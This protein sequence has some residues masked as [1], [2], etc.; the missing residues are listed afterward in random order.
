MIRLR[1]R[2]VQVEVET[3]RH[4]A[5]DFAEPL[6]FGAQWLGQ[7]DGKLRTGVGS[8]FNR[9]R[10]R[11]ASCTPRKMATASFGLKFK[12]SD[13]LD[14]NGWLQGIVLSGAV[15]VNRAAHRCWVCAG[16]GD[17]RSGSAGLTMTIQPIEAVS[18]Q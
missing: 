3:W 5:D 1:A 17:E 12:I 14:P 8:Q 13:G 7:G 16:A 6:H 2:L 10:G 15:P 11:R 9:R 4:K 18:D